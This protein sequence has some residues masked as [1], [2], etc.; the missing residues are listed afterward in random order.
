[1]PFRFETTFVFSHLAG[2]LTALNCRAWMQQ[3][4]QRYLRRPRM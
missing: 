2:K 4:E 3:S 1:M